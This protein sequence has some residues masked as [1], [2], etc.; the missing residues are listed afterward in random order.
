M[1]GIR[2]L[3]ALPRKFGEFC[4]QSTAA[5]FKQIASITINLNDK[6]GFSRQNFMLQQSLLTALFQHF[7][8]LS[9]MTDCK[10]YLRPSLADCSSNS[11]VMNK[12]AIDIVFVD[13]VEF[14]K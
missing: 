11:R 12:L 9:T 2:K 13:I 1:N 5:L 6:S 8:A 7:E 3:G 14:L 10:D 4:D